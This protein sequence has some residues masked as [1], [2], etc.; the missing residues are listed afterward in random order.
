MLRRGEILQRFEPKF[1]LAKYLENENNIRNSPFTQHQLHSITAKISDG[2][3]F[4]PNYVDSGVKFL[5]VKDTRPFSIDYDNSKFI[6]LTEADNLDKRC[7]PQKGDILLTKIGS[8][9]YAAVVESDERFQIFVSLALLRPKT[10]ILVPEYLALCL[11]SQFVY[12]QFER[13]VKG[14]GVPDLHLEN[15][16]QVQIPVPPLDV[17]ARIVAI[18]NA[19]HAAKRAKEAEAHALLGSIDGYVLAELGITLPDQERRAVASKKSVYCVKKGLKFME[20]VSLI[21]LLEKNL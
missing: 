4:T 16:R 17:Q 13:Q 19:A 14:S 21:E 8:I 12:L 2:T 10:D 7:K 1:Y 15:I 18:M 11:N 20:R 9:G 3:H 5:S 6:T